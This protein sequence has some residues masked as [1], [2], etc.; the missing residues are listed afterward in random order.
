VELNQMHKMIKTIR[1]NRNFYELGFHIFEISP[2][3]TSQICKHCGVIDAASR[4]GEIFN[5]TGCGHTEDADEQAS[6][7]ILI[8][9]LAYRH[10]YIKGQKEVKQ[11]EFWHT[12][13]KNKHKVA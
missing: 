1:D 7:N 3:H 4:N 5:C 9:C 2:A 8:K 12:F 6:E 13:V 11:K 10:W